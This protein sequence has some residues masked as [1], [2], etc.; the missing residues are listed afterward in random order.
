MRSPASERMASQWRE[1][2]TLQADSIGRLVQARRGRAERSRREW[3]LGRI[4]AS[5]HPEGVGERV[6]LRL[7][8]F[9]GCSKD[10]PHAHPKKRWLQTVNEPRHA[11]IDTL[12]FGYRCCLGEAFFLLSVSVSGHFCFFL[13]KRNGKGRVVAGLVLSL[14][15]R[16]R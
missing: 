2:T 3:Q 4:H 12:E 1:S 6:R 9:L 16:L 8:L 10:G 13:L 14:V 15:Q 11:F 7:N 5:T